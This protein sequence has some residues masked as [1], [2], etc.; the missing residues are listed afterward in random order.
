[1]VTP[2]SISSL[3][4]NPKYNPELAINNYAKKLA[5]RYSGYLAGG[6]G[7]NYLAKVLSL[8]L[9]EQSQQIDPYTLEQKKN[10]NVNI[11]LS[12]N[13]FEAIYNRNLEPRLQLQIL[14][15]Q[16]KS[17]QAKEESNR[18]ERYK[19]SILYNR[20]DSTPKDIK[21]ETDDFIK[22]YFPNVNGVAK[23]AK[24]ISNIESVISSYSSKELLFSD[25]TLA[26]YDFEKLQSTA[27]LNIN[28]PN[29]LSLTE[30]NST[31]ISKVGNF[32]LSADVTHVA[33]KLSGSSFLEIDPKYPLLNPII[34]AYNPPQGS[35]TLAGSDFNTSKYKII[36]V[37]E[38]KNLEYSFSES[39]Y[40][41][42]D[43]DFLSLIPLQDVDGDNK[44]TSVDNV[45]EHAIIPIVKAEQAIQKT[46]ADNGEVSYSYTAKF[47]VGLAVNTVD[48][49]FDAI[50][51]DLLSKI[52]NGEIEVVV[53]EIG[54]DPLFFTV[55]VIDTTK[56]TG[57][58]L[59]VVFDR[60]ID[61]GVNINIYVHGA[62]LDIASLSVSAK[63][64]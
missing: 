24:Y 34:P 33:V 36:P 51:P 2:N 61:D 37:A 35:L 54:R 4:K 8:A 64:I 57:N 7:S 29:Y 18:I 6:S 15:Q 28:A 30:N 50:A 55:G 31:S 43:P 48:V 14:A 53:N 10:V 56:S 46:V 22:K 21:K 41:N 44:F 11:Q 63:Y 3:L 26:T 25:P 5:S 12:N 32:S 38:L 19:Y 23:D 58:L 20:V 17:L 62:K 59:R 27:S 1:M 47:P 49:N 45:G 13:I 52:A 16:R 39:E 42:N 9:N 60:K 40:A